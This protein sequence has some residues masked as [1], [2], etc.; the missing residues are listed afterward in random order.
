MTSRKQRDNLGVVGLRPLEPKVEMRG[1]HS[2][3]DVTLN[4]LIKERSSDVPATVIPYLREIEADQ[5]MRRVKVTHHGCEKALNV[6][7]VARD[8]HDALFTVPQVATKLSQPFR[9]SH[10]LLYAWKKL[11]AKRG[12]PRAS[13]VASEELDVER[14]LEG[15]QLLGQG[16]L[17]Q[18]QFAGGSP[19]ASGFSD[20]RKDGQPS[21]GQLLV[22]LPTW[23]LLAI[24]V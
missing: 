16:W 22:H 6:N 20:P 1:A 14:L 15:C 21:Q 12:E 13:G 4:Q 19:K 3:I 24:T 23:L 10:E 2:K 8:R 7:G 9:R 5:R 11:P 17:G 18:V